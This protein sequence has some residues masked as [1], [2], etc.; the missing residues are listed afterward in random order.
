MKDDNK[1]VIK[2]EDGKETLMNILFTYDNEERG[3]KYVFMYAPDNEE[4]IICMA[5]DDEGNLSELDDEEYDEAEEVLSA[6]NEDPK[7]QEIK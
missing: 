7:F 4:D 5:Y 3:K 1:I 2:D 6:Y